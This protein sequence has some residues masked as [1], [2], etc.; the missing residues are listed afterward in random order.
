M[1][2]VPPLAPFHASY[3]ASFAMISFWEGGLVPLDSK[4]SAVAW[5]NTLVPL[6]HLF[7]SALPHGMLTNC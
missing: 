3:L 2:P 7:A 1:Y 6:S 4:S 5:A